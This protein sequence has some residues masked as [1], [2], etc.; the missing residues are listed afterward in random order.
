ML[1]ESSRE[2]LS[3]AIELRIKLKL[4]K[5]I[6]TMKI[7]RIITPIIVIVIGLVAYSSCSKNDEDYKKAKS[8]YEQAQKNLEKYAAKYSELENKY[9]KLENDYSTLKDAY[10]KLG[11][12]ADTFL[13]LSKAEQKAKL[14]EAEAEQIEKEEKVKK[15][16]S[17]KK[18]IAKKKEKEKE[19]SRKASERK[20]YDS[21]ITYEKLAR[22]PEKYKGK[23]VTLSGTI[24]QIVEG[25]FDN[26]ARLA[27]KDGFSDIAYI[28]YKP[29]ILDVRLLDYDEVTVYG[30]FKGLKS[31]LSLLGEVTIPNI[32]VEHI[33]LKKK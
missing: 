10:S 28:T 2:N 23:K 8:N 19:N 32:S 14:A 27:T 16:K 13:K 3:K 33:D 15:I 17:E 30:T 12:G 7:G 11:D 5:E 22:S 31:Y 20:Q 4:Y 26:E 9:S 24:I 18:K 6:D 25:A 1:G 21:V 29:D